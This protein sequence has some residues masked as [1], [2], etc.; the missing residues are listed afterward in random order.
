MIWDI[1]LMGL[2]AIGAMFIL[3]SFEINEVL[4]R[5]FKE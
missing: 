3:E 2:A 5:L 1:V 4:K